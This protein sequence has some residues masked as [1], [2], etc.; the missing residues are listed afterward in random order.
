MEPIESEK[1]VD[2]VGF[3]LQYHPCIPSSGWLVSWLIITFRWLT[4]IIEMGFAKPPPQSTFSIFENKWKGFF[5][6]LT[7]STGVGCV[8]HP[9]SSAEMNEKAILQHQGW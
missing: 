2:T 4:G 6:G 8:D 7:C 5:L 1:S 9:S 3:R